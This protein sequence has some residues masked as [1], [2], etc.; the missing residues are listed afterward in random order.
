MP[1]FG[2]TVTA[3]ELTRWLVSVGDIVAIDQPIAEISTDK[4]DTE[5]VASSA[6]PV[7]SL[8]VAVGAIIGVGAPL[9][10]IGS[11]TS[12]ARP[13]ERQAARP[14]STPRARRLAS[15]CG[16]D[17]GSLSSPSGTIRAQDV[18]THRP[19]SVQGFH[20]D[21]PLSAPSGTYLVQHSRV[22]QI[23]ARRT[24]ESLSAAATA[25]SVVEVD[26]SAVDRSRQTLTGQWR[27]RYGHSLT[28]LP[29]VV[30]AVSLALTEYPHLNAE[31]RQD[32]LLVSE[33]VHLGVAVDLGAGGLIVPV[34]REAQTLSVAA[35]AIT[36]Q[37]LAGAARSG[38]LT[39]D[40]LAGSTFAVTNNG[41]YGSVL[42]MPIINQPHVGILSFDA[43]SPKP[44]V[45]TLD[46]GTLAIAVRSK[47]ALALSWDHRAIDSA[48]A[49]K[50]LTHAKTLLE[51]TAWDVTIPS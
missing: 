2:E 41:S 24:R 29:Y 38:T 47:G 14:R 49:A 40:S 1:Q 28:Y 48:Y 36:L 50:F 30:R 43:V 3:G 26:Y 9:L 18:P 11:G 23:A 8:L 33:S 7:T 27:A 45:V 4:V 19:T 44:S 21:A 17:I 16:V 46:D 35:T 51:T 22:R 37:A 12:D 42:T 25:W 31:Y 20:N 32:G 6:G 10:E 13:P 5:V 34:I 15:E 39:A